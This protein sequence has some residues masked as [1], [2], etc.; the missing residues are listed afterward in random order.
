MADILREATATVKDDATLDANGRYF[1]RLKA[2]N[3]LAGIDE[4]KLRAAQHSVILSYEP[5]STM[6]IDDLQALDRR[7]YE[8][9]R[10]DLEMESQP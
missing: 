7:I 9:A 8:L 5:G 6:T 2:L 1:E 3:D 4:K 10:K